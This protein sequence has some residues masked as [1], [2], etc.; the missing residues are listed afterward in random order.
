MD[1]AMVEH[2]CVTYL[3]WLAIENAALLKV[4][5][6]DLCYEQCLSRTDRQ[7]PTIATIG[8]Y[9]GFPVTPGRSPH[10]R[11]LPDQPMAQL[12]TN[13]AEIQNVLAMHGVTD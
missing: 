1:P 8:R 12:F 11:V 2:W 9:V 4:P 7:S 6:L 3:A 5:H 13:Y 10:I